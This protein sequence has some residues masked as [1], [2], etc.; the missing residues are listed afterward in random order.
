MADLPLTAHH[1]PHTAGGLFFRLDYA[2]TLR[3][4]ILKVKTLPLEH[5]SSKMEELTAPAW[6]VDINPGG[7]F[8]FLVGIETADLELIPQSFK[9]ALPLR[10][11]VNIFIFIHK[12]N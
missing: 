2:V 11:L 12:I 1:L 10:M 5:L 8:Q 6:L 3:A 4:H 9:K 7:L